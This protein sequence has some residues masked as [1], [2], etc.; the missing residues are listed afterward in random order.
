MLKRIQK[1]LL[2][3]YPLVWNTKIIPLSCALLVFNLIFFILGYFR[4]YLDFNET[5]DNYRYNNDDN[6][7]GFSVALAI[8]TAIIWL[9]FYLK[10][11]AFK[12]FY[13]RK[14]YSLYQEWMLILLGSLLMCAM[15]VSFLWGEQVRVRSYFSE[16][17]AK[18]RCE[19]LSSASI[20][21]EGSFRNNGFIQ[22]DSLGYTV[23]VPVDHIKFKGRRYPLN[24][25]LNKNMYDFSFFGRETNS[26]R[27]QKIF[28]WLVNNRKD[29][30]AA[31]F[32]KFLAIAD[33]HH[34]RGNVDKDKWLQL[35]YHYPDFAG[36]TIVANENVIFEYEYNRRNHDSI[37][38][39][40]QYLKTIN[41]RQ[42]I[43]NKHFVPGKKLNYS[44]N[45]ISDAWTNPYVDD[46]AILVSICFA[47]GFSILVFSFRASTGRNWLIALIVTGV[48]SIIFG[49]IMA[50]TRY[51]EIYG[52]LLFAFALLLCIYFF[53]IL[54]KDKTKEISGIVLNMV[55][56]IFPFMLPLAYF[57]LLE[58]SYNY[59]DFNELQSV[60]QREKY[61]VI[62]FLSE[63][64]LLILY[65]N[66][67]FIL[68]GMLFFSVKI[69]KW[70]GIAES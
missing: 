35:T 23:Q 9:V 28:T 46:E 20:F 13:P 31:L 56:W 7:I 24:S 34:L 18:K 66:I 70:K 15:P 4:G 64:N 44:Y 17:E 2:V 50:F 14:K 59:T 26:L 63:N 40:N 5:S 60:V 52:Y 19:I 48:M 43:F 33:E 68:L 8:L 41:G 42:Y 27:S 11:N 58:L 69:K 3:H 57:L 55:L 21:T 25:L 37:D 38:T 36:D 29:S 45:K 53:Y 22:T 12:S 39:L 54:R 32:T 6:I 61:P 1:Y 67:I 49:I 62:Y 65:V 16:S 30:V 10:N 51:D 47:L